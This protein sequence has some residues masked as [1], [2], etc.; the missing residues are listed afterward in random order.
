[1]KT[2]IYTIS[3]LAATLVSHSQLKGSGKTITK[4][5]DFK[6]FDKVY[7]ENLDGKLE[8]EI[9][10]PFSITVTID[11]NLID[12]FSITENR[13][14]YEL[15][16]SFKDNWNNKKYIENTNCKIKITMPEASVIKNIGNSNLNIK[17][18]IGR[19]FR[20]ENTGN[21][22]TKISGSTDSFDVVK[23]GNGNISAEKLIAKKANIKNTG[24]GDVTVNVSEELTAQ[25]N[26]NG[27]VKNIGKAKFDN[28]SKKTG[29]GDLINY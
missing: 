10:K 5:Y 7:F 11:D 27:D 14:E 23:R 8:V 24:N 29:N 28:N 21:G 22:D 6:N 12:I 4:T 19:Y 2:I 13:T 16:L 9:G 1:M 18:V 3:F 17:N 15:T 26:G 25:L 20:I